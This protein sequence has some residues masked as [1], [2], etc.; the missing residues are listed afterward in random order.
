MYVYIFF[1]DMKCLRIPIVLIFSEQS[2]D[3]IFTYFFL[4]N[5]VVK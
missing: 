2:F 3:H 4:L 1:L 5:S